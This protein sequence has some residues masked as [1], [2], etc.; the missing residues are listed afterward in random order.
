MVRTSL[1]KLL[2]AVAAFACVLGLSSAGYADSCFTGNASCTA[3]GTP[4]SCCTGSGTG[5]CASQ[6]PCTLPCPVPASTVYEQIAPNSQAR[7]SIIVCDLDPS[8]TLY[9]VF[10]LPLL[11]VTYNYGLPVAPGKC[12]N[13]GINPPNPNANVHTVTTQIGVITQ[14]GTAACSFFDKSN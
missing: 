10:G 14:T 7:S 4:Y 3:A 9:V 12:Q 2:A 11:T 8:T 1:R 13:F 6:S 5:S